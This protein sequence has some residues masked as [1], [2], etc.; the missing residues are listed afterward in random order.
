MLISGTREIQRT[1]IEL[2]N[3][4]DGFD[5]RSD[6]KVMRHA[7]MK[8]AVM[9]LVFMKHAVYL[10]IRI[11]LF[12]IR[13]YSHISYT[14]LLHSPSHTPYSFSHI[15]PGDHGDQQNRSTGS[16]FDSSRAYRSKDRVS[17]ARYQNEEKYFQDSYW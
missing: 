13:P 7:V 8:L 16:C 2:L 17:L 6:V 11:L 14:H 4:L 9:K 12:P 3:Q 15:Y 5:E 1:M 10:I